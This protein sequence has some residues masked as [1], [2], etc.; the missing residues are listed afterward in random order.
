[1]IN[2]ECKGLREKLHPRSPLTRFPMKDLPLPFCL[3]SHNLYTDGR[4]FIFKVV[5]N[6]KRIKLFIVGS[7]GELKFE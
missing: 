1:M 2:Y 6:A 3:S 5:R 4:T 7:Y